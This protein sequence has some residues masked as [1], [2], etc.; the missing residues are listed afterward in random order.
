MGLFYR[1]WSEIW[2]NH[3]LLLLGLASVFA[4]ILLSYILLFCFNPKVFSFTQ[5]IIW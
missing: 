5:C 1:G 4:F 3:S 2:K